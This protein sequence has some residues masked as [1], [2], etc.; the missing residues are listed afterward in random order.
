MEGRIKDGTTKVLRTYSPAAQKNLARAFAMKDQVDDFLIG[1]T[2]VGVE[3]GTEWLIAVKRTSP[4]PNIEFAFYIVGWD[5]NGNYDAIIEKDFT[6]PKTG[7]PRIPFMCIKTHPRM[8]VT[9]FAHSIIE[10]VFP[11]EVEPF[12]KKPVVELAIQL[13]CGLLPAMELYATKVV[14]VDTAEQLQEWMT[15]VWSRL[16]FTAGKDAREQAEWAFGFR[17]KDDEGTASVLVRRMHQT[18]T[19]ESP[20]HCDRNNFPMKVCLQKLTFVDSLF[21]YNADL[22]PRIKEGA[23][24]IIKSIAAIPAL[25]ITQIMRG[26]PCVAYACKQRVF[27]QPDWNRIKDVPEE[28]KAC[29]N[30]YCI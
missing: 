6:W 19:D 8:Y 11:R 21:Y 26:G 17:P 28:Y 25:H 12:G 5:Q 22:L 29:K 4:A 27:G 9:E 15:D 1:K 16:G 3:A 13:I 20:I 14:E 23:S 24:S 30:V 18:E 7:F 2:E 10:A